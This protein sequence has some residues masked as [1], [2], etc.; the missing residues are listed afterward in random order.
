MKSRL[1]MIVGLK[2]RHEDSTD[3]LEAGYMTIY[4]GKLAAQEET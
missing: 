4:T 3:R 2:S 1:V